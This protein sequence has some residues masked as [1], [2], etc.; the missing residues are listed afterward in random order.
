MRRISFVALAL[1][2]LL[3]AGT[4]QAAAISGTVTDA[5]T[6]GRLPAMV[7]RAYTAA[8]FD[9]GAATSDSN[10]RYI[11]SLP[12]GDYRILAYDQNGVYATTFAGNA[13]SFETSSVLNITNV[14]VP[15]YNFALRLAGYITGRVSSPSDVIPQAVVAAYN[16]SGTR[17]GFTVADDNG[18]FQLVVPPGKYKVVAYDDSKHY[19]PQFFQ[20]ASSFASATIIEVAQSETAPRADVLLPVAGRITGFVVDRT[21][22]EP[23]GG[24]IIS[25]YDEDG[26]LVTT[27][28]MAADQ[29]DLALAAGTYRL[30]VADIT[31]RYAPEFYGGAEAF[32]DSTPVAITAG[33]LQLGLRFDVSPAGH[34]SGRVVKP[35]NTPLPNISVAAY[36]TDGV[37]RATAQSGIDGAYQIDVPPGSFKLV[38]YD[39]ALAYAPKFYQQAADFATSTVLTIASGQTV[40]A[41]FAMNI[42][43]NFAGTARDAVTNV[44]VAGIDIAAYSA[45]GTRV[46]SALTDSDGRYR[47]VVPAG[48][49]R[50]IA[51]DDSLRYVTTFVG[52]KAFETSME[53]AVAAGAVA[54]MNF[55]LQRG[56]LFSG[57]VT[58]VAQRPVSGVDIAILDLD[59][60]R[61]ATAR[62]QNGRFNVVLAPGTYKLF[63]ADPERRYAVSFYNGA[64]SFAAA[65][66][67]TIRNDVPP[68]PITFI[69]APAPRRRAVGR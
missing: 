43:G 40:T 68:A 54:T 9:A 11:L 21:T 20:N 57:T 1:L 15:N 66:A 56:I 36:F 39:N 32:A 60:N 50:L 28:Q 69:L 6:G 35:D 51:S 41:D 47:I 12:A 3:G 58:D 55:Q 18:N 42:G 38:A 34:I 19:A 48:A 24:L 2:S 4:A 65:T 27:Q 31:H 23:V 22:G 26:S 37:L 16:L 62:S 59:G 17:R 61:V 29:F 63:A 49:Y 45:D 13:D 52:A 30:V 10:G 44:P 25:A 67:L 53:T 64:R 5:T 14:D 7:V 46:A 8:G 33:G